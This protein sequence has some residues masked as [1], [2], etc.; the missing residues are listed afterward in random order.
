MVSGAGCG[1]TVV[2]GAAGAGSEATPERT[3]T[4]CAT[5]SNCPDGSECCALTSRCYPSSDPEQ[6]RLP[7]PGT[8][9]ACTAD[10][11][12]EPYQYCAGD[13]CS[14]PGGC[15]QRGSSEDCGVTYEL[16]CGCDGT[17]YTSPACAESRGVRVASEGECARD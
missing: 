16:V 11:Q 10:D 13:G 1:E 2:I 7:P 4:A 5:S 17:T 14:G 3:Y 15:K 9:R 6:C 12:C 8:T